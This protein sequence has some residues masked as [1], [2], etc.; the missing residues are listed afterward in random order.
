MRILKIGAAV[1]LAAAIASGVQAKTL[2]C[3]PDC[4]CVSEVNCPCCLLNPS[5]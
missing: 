2:P 5:K 1:L 3:V 4:V